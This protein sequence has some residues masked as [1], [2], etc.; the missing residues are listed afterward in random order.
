MIVGPWGEVL[1]RCE[2]WDEVV[3]RGEGGSEGGEDVGG[4]ERICVAEVER[5]VVDRVRREVPLKRRL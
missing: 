5:G 3:K 4:M 1:G 2:S